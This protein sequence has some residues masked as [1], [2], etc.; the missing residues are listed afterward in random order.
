ML[1]QRGAGIANHRNGERKCSPAINTRVKKIAY[2]HA[3]L[4]TLVLN[5]ARCV[6]FRRP[7]KYLK[8]DNND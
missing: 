7:A 4:I 5:T 3:V 1:M 8:I 2:I 6:C